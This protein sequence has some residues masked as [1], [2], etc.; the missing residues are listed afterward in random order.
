MIVFSADDMGLGKTLTMISLVIR[1]HELREGGSEDEK[2]AWLNRDKQLE[3][4][5]IPVILCSIFLQSQ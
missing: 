3:K 1:Q 5:N 2:S 4:C